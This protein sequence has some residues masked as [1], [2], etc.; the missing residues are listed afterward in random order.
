MGYLCL[1]PRKRRGRRDVE[2]KE[3]KESCIGDAVV[4]SEGGDDLV[5]E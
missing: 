1:W 4:G 2:R 3:G 5:A